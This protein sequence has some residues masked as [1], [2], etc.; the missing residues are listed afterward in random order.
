MKLTIFGYP[1]CSTVK[2]AQAW[3]DETVGGHDYTHFSKLD[4]LAACIDDWVAKAGIDAV[5]N[6]RAQTFKKMEP[7]EQA[8][9]TA[10]DDAKKAAMAADPRLIK[11][12]VGT[13]GRTVLTGFKADDWAAAFS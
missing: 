8:A 2:R 7:S 9:I 5:F 3:A 6:D 1:G 4:D 13:D 12:P 11:R 10:S